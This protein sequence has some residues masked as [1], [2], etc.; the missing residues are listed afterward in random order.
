MTEEIDIPTVVSIAH[1]VRAAFPELENRAFAV[2]EAGLTKENMPNLP[3]AFIALLGMSSVN[4]SNNVNTPTDL[5]ETICVEFWLP[6]Q[7]YKRE[8]GSESPFYAFQDYRPTMEKLFNALTGYFTPQRKPVRLLTMDT[9]ADE[10]CQ[11][12]CFKFSVE[13]RWCPTPD[14]AFNPVRMKS[15]SLEIAKDAG[16]SQYQPPSECE[17]NGR[18]P[19]KGPV[20]PSIPDPYR[21][22]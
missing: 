7:V 19:F 6:S 11:T 17:A 15:F 3:L 1:L 16:G 20:V 21:K 8:D 22:G 18:L 13:W 2:A 14:D 9:T 5:H 4:Q 12:I 10:Y